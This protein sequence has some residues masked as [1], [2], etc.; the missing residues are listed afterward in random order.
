MLHAIPKAGVKLALPAVKVLLL[1]E[2]LLA[3][4]WPHQQ[5]LY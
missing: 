1:I 3:E 2:V 5:S 4:V